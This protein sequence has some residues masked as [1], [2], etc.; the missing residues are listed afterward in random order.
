MKIYIS[1]STH[2]D[3]ENNL[4]QVLRNSELNNK[5][6]IFL[7]HEQSVAPV[8]SKDY[9]KQCDLVVAE[10]S[11]PATGQGI[12]LGWANVFET[13]IVCVFKK[14]AKTARSL[15]IVSTDFIEYESGADLV[16]KLAA[17]LSSYK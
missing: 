1:H 6:E 5:Y 15:Q 10:V 9:I 12:E 7:P 16:Q 14:G 11:Y 17:Y 4:Y 13:P 8:S 3:Y 2:A